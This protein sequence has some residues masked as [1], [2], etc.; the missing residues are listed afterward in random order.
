MLC[1]TA[2]KTRAWLKNR[3]EFPI[4]EQL[5][6]RYDTLISHQA[7]FHRA[8]TFCELSWPLFNLSVSEEWHGHEER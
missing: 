6:M 5:Q 2:A 4:D 8:F 1:E 3:V 7:I